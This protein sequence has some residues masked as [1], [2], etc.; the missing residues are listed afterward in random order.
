MPG[1]VC[2]KKYTA[3]AERNTEIV[4]IIFYGD[5]YAVNLFHEQVLLVSLFFRIKSPFLHQI[6]NED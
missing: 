2:R 5:H 1:A 6:H 4:G 3:Q